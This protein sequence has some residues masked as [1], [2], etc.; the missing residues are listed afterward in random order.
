MSVFTDLLSEQ[1]LY[2][3]EVWKYISFGKKKPGQSVLLK[4]AK[5]IHDLLPVYFS[6]CI[7]F[8]CMLVLWEL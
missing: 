5:P 8:G 3:S 7:P 4:E 6:Q 2:L 1:T